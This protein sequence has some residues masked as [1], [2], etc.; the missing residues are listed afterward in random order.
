MLVLEVY[1]AL[2]FVVAL[3]TW[4]NY[5]WP[6]MREAYQKGVRNDL[7]ESP[8]LGSLVF[9]TIT[10]LLA[11]FVL[12]TVFSSAQ[13]EYFRLGLKRIIEEDQD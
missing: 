2:A 12:V 1:F 4:V 5:F 9:I 13:G 6:T 3:L 11:P 7:V 8:V 10:T